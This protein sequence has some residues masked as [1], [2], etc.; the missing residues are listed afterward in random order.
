[1]L[2]RGCYFSGRV[3][4]EEFGMTPDGQRVDAFTLSNIDGM[5]AKILTYGATLNQLHVQDADGSF[6]DVVLGFDTLDVSHYSCL[7]IVSKVVGVL[8]SGKPLFWSL[9]GSFHWPNCGWHLYFI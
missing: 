7:S 4:K 5:T 9:P 1:M 6:S 8:E 2:T 3:E